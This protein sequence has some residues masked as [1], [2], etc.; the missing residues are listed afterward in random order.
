MKKLFSIFFIITFPQY[1]TQKEN[2]K[3][4]NSTNILCVDGNAALMK[5]KNLVGFYE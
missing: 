1:F 5:I 4:K 3:K 2:E